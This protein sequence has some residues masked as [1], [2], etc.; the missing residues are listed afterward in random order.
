L[1]EI[2]P[3]DASPAFFRIINVV[4]PTKNLLELSADADISLQ[5]VFH[6]VS[7]LVFWGK[8]TVIFPLCET[9]VYTVHPLAT[10]SMT[11]EISR[12]FS[13]AFT[14]NLLTLL[15]DFSLGVTLSQL[16]SPLQKQ[17]N[18]VAQVKWM[19][20]HRLLLQ[21]HCYVYLI[22]LTKKPALRSLKNNIEGA[23]PISC[24]PGSTGRSSSLTNITS[25]AENTS[26]TGYFKGDDDDGASPRPPLES[27]ASLLN[28][29]GLNDAEREAILR[30]PAA[31]NLDDLKLFSRLCPYFNGKR[32]LED[33]IYYENVRRS[34]LLALI[35]KFRDVLLTCQYEDSAVAQLCP[36]N[37][38]S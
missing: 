22:P 4:T 1:K 20:R 38:L 34:Q 6:I 25:V 16:R 2:L 36:Y 28:G 32:H 21:L 7:Q 11:S 37:F 29:L 26:F 17:T 18:L 3:Q 31:R 33:I 15:S 10:S 24:E 27:G 23:R 19:L 13:S 5:Q 12:K 30:V 8:A 9:N 35:D 14:D